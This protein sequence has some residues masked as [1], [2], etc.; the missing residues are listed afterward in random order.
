MAEPA[1]PNANVL[2]RVAYVDGSA[3]VE[4]LWSTAL[5]NDQYKLD[6]TPFYAYSVSWEDTVFAPFDP[7]EGMPTYQRVV[8]KSGNRTIR[9]RFDP[10]CA[11]GKYIGQS[12]QRTS[13]AGLQL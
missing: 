3:E 6:N 8:E 7:D 11:S 5:G 12:P 13:V 9:V 2:F 1:T 10:P 4:T